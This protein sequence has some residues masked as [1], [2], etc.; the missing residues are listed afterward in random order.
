MKTKD[1]EAL[2][3]ENAFFAALDP[4]DVAM[5]AG[6][7]THCVFRKD[8]QIAQENQPADRFFLIRKGKVAI[9]T[10]VPHRGQV[11]LQSIGRG[12]ILGWSWLFPPYVWMFDVRALEDTRMIA[13]DGKCLREKCESHHSMGYRLMKAFASVMADRIRNT[14]LQVLD[15]YQSP[16]GGVS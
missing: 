13:L 10:H 3:L 2:L 6:C 11:L 7:G 14:R 15:M 4:A 12:E 16:G 1:I 9:E 8:E 5:I